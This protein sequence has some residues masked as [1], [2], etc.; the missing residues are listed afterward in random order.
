[1]TM[2]LAL[3]KRNVVGMLGTVVFALLAT[4]GTHAYVG[5]NPYAVEMHAPSGAVRCDGQAQVTATVRSVETG[6][7]VPGQAVLW[8]FK[9]NVSS[10]DRVAPRRTVTDENGKTTVTVTFGAAEGRRT[11]RAMIA[12]WPNTT[13]VTC[14]GGVPN[15]TPRPTPSPTP[16]PTRSPTPRPTAEAPSPGA[17]TGNPQPTAVASEQ[18][19]ASATPAPSALSTLPPASSSA[20]P[21]TDG[22]AAET[23][24]ATP[25]SG[26]GPTDQPSH[27]AVAT[28]PS[29]AGQPPTVLQ[30]SGF[31]FLIPG[32][33]GL[34]GIVA[35]TSGVLVFRRR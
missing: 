34:V 17:P 15:P 24:G 19:A 5:Q 31:D 16:R 20:P 29:D 26:T 27:G 10:G 2:S 1:M 6:V 13:K 33:L 22:V 21:A 32:L 35:V 12:N 30:S 23:P 11:V 9:S 25:D 8:D 14:A 18:P 4:T 3:R 7:V 28:A